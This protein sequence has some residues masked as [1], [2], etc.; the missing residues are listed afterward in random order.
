MTQRI[1]TIAEIAGGYDAVVFDQWGVLHDGTAPYPGAVRCLEALARPV[2]VL[3]NSGKRAAPNADRI[4]AM[5]FARPF[6]TVMTSGEALWRDLDAGLIPHRRLYPIERAPGDAEHWAGGLDVTLTG[7]DACEAILLMGLPDGSTL[8]A[9][10]PMLERARA[11]GLPLYCSNPDRASPRRGGQVISP[12]A[13][14]FAYRDMGGEVAFYGKP[15]RPIFDSLAAALGTSRLLM[16][17]DSL[18]HDI[19]G[20]AQAGWDSVFVG[21]GLYADTFSTGDWAQALATLAPPHAP[22]YFIGALQ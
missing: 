4:A 5:G 14:A 7:F 19:A 10:Q 3:S 1:D 6:D 21:G 12:G 9:W 17:G 16:V 20:A 2:A 22:T 11:R 13:L 18:E 15:H 8:G